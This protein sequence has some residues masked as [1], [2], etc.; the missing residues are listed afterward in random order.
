MKT[1]KW[2][3]ITVTAVLAVGGLTILRARANDANPAHFGRGH[4][5]AK[6]KKQLGLSD[7][8][9]SKIRGEFVTDKTK[10]T[11]LL[12]AWHDAR[13][14]LREV[15]QKP[16]STEA[17]IRAAAAKVAAVEADLAVERASLYGRI[18]PILTAD[19]LD[20]VVEFQQRVDDYIDGAIIG[21]GKRLAD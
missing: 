8:Q 19:Q 21:F 7:E 1:S 3:V 11:G 18:S 5:L 20:K 12:T 6:A 16:G 4:F 9:V 13:V 10:L 15:I 2:L 17:D 14:N